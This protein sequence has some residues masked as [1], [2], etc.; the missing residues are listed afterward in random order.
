[1]EPQDKIRQAN[2]VAHLIRLIG[3]LFFIAMSFQVITWKYAMFG[4]VACF[5]IAPVV[6]RLMV[7]Q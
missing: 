5:I 7:N 6:R 3:V 4:G 2:S 1:M